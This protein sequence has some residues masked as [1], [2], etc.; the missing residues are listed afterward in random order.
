M[1]KFFGEW[2]SQKNKNITTKAENGDAET[3]AP[4][5]R[6]PYAT[7]IVL[8]VVLCNKALALESAQ[9]SV[10]YARQ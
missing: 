10:P 3:D 9:R 6:L 4:A 7:K 5:V 8:R 1:S 2:R